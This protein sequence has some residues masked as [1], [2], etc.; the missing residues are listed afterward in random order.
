L[1]TMLTSKTVQI[2][3]EVDYKPKPDQQLQSQR[4]TTGT[5]C[6]NTS[7]NPKDSPKGQTKAQQSFYSY[8]FERRLDNATVPVN[9]FLHSTLK[10]QTSLTMTKTTSTTTNNKL[11]TNTLAATRTRT[12][13]KNLKARD[14][15][16]SQ[17]ENKKKKQNKK[18][19]KRAQ[20]KKEE[21]DRAKATAELEKVMEVTV[22][23]PANMENK[24]DRPDPKINEYIGDINSAVFAMSLTETVE[25]AT[26]N[27]GHNQTEAVQFANEI[28]ERK[29]EALYSMTEEE[30]I[31]YA[32]TTLGICKVE[33]ELYAA[34]LEERKQEIQK[35]QDQASLLEPKDADELLERHGITAKDLFGKGATAQLSTSL[36][37]QQ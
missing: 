1:T 9:K 20:E 34:H 26:V 13:K 35:V 23:S 18:K 28:Q 19:K 10:I 30:T 32:T 22:V 4:R 24:A 15:L 17:V 8:S 11:A 14:E 27:L 5:T 7:Q 12:A 3:T 2:K 25:F 36:T 21:E 16:L 33:A 31:E 29:M 6:Q 37:W